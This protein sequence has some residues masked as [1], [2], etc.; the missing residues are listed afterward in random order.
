[1][2]EKTKKREGTVIRKW[3]KYK[4]ICQSKNSQKK[5]LIFFFKS[6]SLVNF[7]RYHIKLTL[8]WVWGRLRIIFYFK[9]VLPVGHQAGIMAHYTKK[10]GNL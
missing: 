3:G 2:R 5:T 6:V 7:T 10:Q 4:R 9:G 1:M 8:H